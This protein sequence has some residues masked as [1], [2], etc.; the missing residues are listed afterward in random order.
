MMKRNHSFISSILVL[1]LLASGTSV[2]AAPAR[3]T[4][5]KTTVT[6]TKTTNTTKKKTVGELLSQANEAS[7]G[8]RLQMSKTDTSI[9]TGNYTFKSDV[10]NVNLDNVKPPPS[11]ELMKK[12]GSSKEQR[13]Y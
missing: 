8:A 2:F 9:P 13:E 7:R 5:K 10:T 1:S 11:S 3:T 6:K 12:E 4:K